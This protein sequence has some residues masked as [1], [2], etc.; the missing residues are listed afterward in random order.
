MELEIKNCVQV[1]LVWFEI[2]SKWQLNI[3]IKTCSTHCHFYKF[4]KILLNAFF[5]VDHCSIYFIAVSVIIG[6]HRKKRKLSQETFNSSW[7][8]FLGCLDLSSKLTS[9]AKFGQEIQNRKSISNLYLF[10][11]KLLKISHRNCGIKSIVDFPGQK[12]H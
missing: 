8:T 4:P 9:L 12:Y 11:F 2:F 7:Q 5:G 3:S 1:D 10:L 6:Y